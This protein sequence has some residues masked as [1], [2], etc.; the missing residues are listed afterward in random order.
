[1]S[2]RQSEKNVGDW[3]RQLAL[4]LDLPF[5]LIGAV[6]GGG[7]IGYLI[8][9][10]LHTAPWLMLGCGLLGFAGGFRELLR[11]LARRGGQGSR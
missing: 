2:P 8:D 7:F 5:L 4:A 11:S 6:L 3:V 1:M 9:E 10:W